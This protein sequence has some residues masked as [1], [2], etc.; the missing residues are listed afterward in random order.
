MLVKRQ[1]WDKW[2]VVSNHLQT[3]TYALSYIWLLLLILAKSGK[4]GV[5]ENWMYELICETN[6]SWQVQRGAGWVNTK[7]FCAVMSTTFFPLCETLENLWVW[8]ALS[9]AIQIAWI[10]WT[11]CRPWLQYLVWEQQNFI[12]K[13]IL[14]FAKMKPITFA[15]HSV[16]NIW[17]RY[18]INP[19]RNV[20]SFA[21]FPSFGG[22]ELAH[23]IK[24]FSIVFL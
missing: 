10:N 1:L 6:V 23:V 8:A 21:S 4:Y 3:K 5:H 18:K 9:L 2:K 24:K 14:I 12:K 7:P 19:S 20:A 16:L 15:N 11:G 13:N 22:N 17:W